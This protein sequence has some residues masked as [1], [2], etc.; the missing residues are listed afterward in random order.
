MKYPESEWTYRDHRVQFLTPHRASQNK[1]NFLNLLLHFKKINQL[2][3]RC[4]CFSTLSN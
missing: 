4:L 1:C 2:E 3:T